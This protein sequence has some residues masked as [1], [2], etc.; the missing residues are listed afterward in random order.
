MFPTELNNAKVLYYTPH[1]NYGAIRYPNGEI[2]HKTALGTYMFNEMKLYLQRHQ[3]I[4]NLG[5][6][7][8]KLKQL[9]KEINRRQQV[10]KPTEELNEL[11]KELCVTFY[12]YYDAFSEE[13][14]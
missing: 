9:K 13:V 7:D 3:L 8:A 12:E 10:H 2:Y 5:R 11:Y 1:D 6:V 4:Y 14:E